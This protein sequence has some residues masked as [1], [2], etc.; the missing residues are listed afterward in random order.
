M[1]NHEVQQQGEEGFFDIEKLAQNFS[2]QEVPMK[3]RK[4][5]LLKEVGLPVPRVEILAASDLRSLE[6]SIKDRIGRGE[7]PLMIRF[8]CNPDR[9]SMPT[10]S[11]ETGEPDELKAV[12]TNI[13]NVLAANHEIK[14]V[15]L[16]KMTPIEKAGT[17]ISGRITYESEDL[18]PLQS[19]IE[20]Y[21]GSRSTSVLDRLTPED[22]NYLRFEKEAGRFLKLATPLKPNSSIAVSEY[23]HVLTSLNSYNE[24]TK[25]VVEVIAKSRGQQQS[26]KSTS[27]EFS[28]NESR[29]LFIDID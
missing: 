19:I 28:Y 12:N 1:R 24:Q 2:D 26:P 17:K 29:I 22:P 10:F 7:L 4:L 20:L 23:T 21:K 18:M 5:N 15:I 3:I 11:V 9:Y 27:I 14:D 16:Q 8:A 6:R 13:A 25:A